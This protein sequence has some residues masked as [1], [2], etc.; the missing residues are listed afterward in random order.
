MDIKNSTI[1]WKQ[2]INSKW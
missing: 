2:T 1:L